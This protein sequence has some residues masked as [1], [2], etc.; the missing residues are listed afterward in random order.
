[1]TAGDVLRRLRLPLFILGLIIFIFTFPA[2]VWPFLASL[3]LSILLEPA[4]HWVERKGASRTAAVA[5]VF[6]ALGV[7]VGVFFLWIVPGIIQD[8]NKALAR[9]PGYAK[10][11]QE[12]VDHYRRMF[13]RLPGN[14]QGFINMGILQGEEILRK[15]LV[16]LA[17]GILALFSRA[18]PLLLVPVLSFY[19]SRDLR[20]WHRIVRRRAEEWFGKDGLVLERTVGVVAGYV[21]GQIVDSMAVGAL[22]AL[23]LLALRID[24]ALLIG[25][26]AGVFNL[27]PYF[28]PVIGAAPAMVL[29]GLH[30]PW[31]ALY[32]ILLFFAVNQIEAMVLV[33]RIVGRRIG[34]HPVVVIFLLLFGGEYLGFFGMLLAV[35]IGAVLQVLISYYLNKGRSER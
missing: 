27:I 14:L 20:K 18:L 29:A 16:R 35:P 30:S 7:V 17:S 34:L 32:V 5:T 10:E 8:L 12:A 1:M 11:I 13:R 24:L 4:V 23:G 28:G 2:V 9:F 22:L 19:I 6:L 21:R 15:M 31:H 26:L 25:A 33:P 3:A